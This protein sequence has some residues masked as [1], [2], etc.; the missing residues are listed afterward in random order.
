MDTF[1]VQVEI[2]ADGTLELRR[3]VGI[4]RG[5]AHA[6]E[7]RRADAVLLQQRAQKQRPDL[8]WQIERTYSGKYVVRGLSNA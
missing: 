6:T 8:D 5:R 7:V 4:T 2:S 1:Y 3:L